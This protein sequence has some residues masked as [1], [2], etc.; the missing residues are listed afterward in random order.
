MKRLLWLV[1]AVSAGCG[2]G[3]PA[4]PGDRAPGR[5][6]VILS[7]DGLPW[8]LAKE[9]MAEGKMPHLAAL[10]ARGAA[11]EG[12]S[13]GAFPAK[14]APCHATLW[15]G[16]WA[17]RH[18]I[19]ANE[20]PLLP[21]MTHTVFETRLGFD[22]EALRAEPLWRA[23]ARAGRT[24][25][26]VQA[27]HAD[28]DSDVDT[29]FATLHMFNG[30][31]NLLSPAMI[32][33]SPFSVDGRNFRVER[34]PGGVAVSCG[35]L[36]ATVRP[37]EFV[38]VDHPDVRGVF[39]LYLAQFDDS[40]WTLLRS[41]CSS[42][43]ATS[44]EERDRFRRECGG[45][46]YNTQK[47]GDTLWDGTAWK[48]DLYLAATRL[49]VERVREA[50]LWAMREHPAEL[51]FT[52]LPQPDEALHLLLGRI[53]VLGDREA[54]DVLD[55]VLAL[56]DGLVGD[57]AAA[58]GPQGAIAVVS[59]HGMAPVDRVFYPNLALERAGLLTRG[60][61]GR[62]DLSKTQAVFSPCAGDFVTV[63]T[64]DRRGGIVPTEDRDAWARLAERAILAAATRSLGEGTLLA[65]RPGDTK[66]FGLGKEGDVW[67]SATSD[68]VRLNARLSPDLP[69]PE[70]SLVRAVAPEGHHSGDP[71]IP[72]LRGLMVF[73]GPGFRHASADGVRHV[74]F[75][76][77][78][79][80]WLGIDPPRDAVGTAL[81]EF[82][83]EP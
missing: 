3:E 52:Y 4:A 36:R 28:P 67:F 29:G 75:A 51:T 23:A 15:T 69:G 32:E 19:H 50:T 37:G 2:P 31:R 41:S 22:A 1:L 65:F 43:G 57:L 70:A 21:R 45:Y 76:P 66:D 64:T 48:R 17:D 34:I 59:D 26:V 79:A 39:Y 24:V 11:A 5:R 49:N 63:N 72:R 83:E 10:V 81:R 12:G 46:A 80:A 6:L 33:A 55:G 18:G 62:I 58:V 35:A 20:T 27:T 13:I 30:Y 73:A 7:L 16:C 47:L 78:V 53:E 71:R 61:T 82:L 38:G 68:G 42:V 14:T 54:A 77:T 25:T 74:D 56:C 8:D 60:A 44:R 40:S 9:K